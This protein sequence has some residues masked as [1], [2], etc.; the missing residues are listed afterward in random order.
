MTH[1]FTLLSLVV[2]LTVTACSSEA[3]IGSGATTTTAAGVT[4]TTAGDVTTT[5]AGAAA[6]TVAADPAT[7]TTPAP[8]TP[9]PTTPAPPATPAPTVAPPA[10][11]TTVP[12]RNVGNLYGLSDVS[13]VNVRRGDCGEGVQQVQDQL[14]YKLGISLTVDGRFGP[15]TEA[16]VRDFQTSVGL[17]VDGIVGPNTWVA[18]TDDGT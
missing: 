2:L 5:A 4:T 6:S 18:L 12:C 11:A 9:A 13:G 3:S 1:R 15:G 10:P 8:T 14:N 16:A 7:P 17:P